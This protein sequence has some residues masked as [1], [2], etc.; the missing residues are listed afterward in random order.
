M[1]LMAHQQTAVEEARRRRFLALFY[2]TGTGKT[3]IGLRVM[4][5]WYRIGLRRFICAVPNTLTGVWLKEADKFEF[6]LRIVRLPVGRA[7]RIALIESNSWDVLVCN[8]EGV[9]NLYEDIVAQRPQGLLCDEMQ[10]L[11]DRSAVQ[12]K[13][14]KAIARAVKQNGGNLI[15]LTGTPVIHS[16]FD[17]WSEFDILWPGA[18][19]TE[20]VL[21]F[22][23]YW[24]FE[25]SVSISRPHPHLR[26]V[27][28][29]EFPPDRLETLRHRVAKHAIEA[30]K[31]ACLDLPDRAFNVVSIDMEPEQQRVYDALKEDFLA[32]LEQRPPLASATEVL[33]DRGISNTDIRPDFTP[34]F[35][36]TLQ[37][38]STRISVTMATTLL[39]RLQQIAAGFAV[40]DDKSVVEL[41]NAKADFVADMLPLW[42]TDTHKLILFA[43]FKHDILVLKSLCEKAKIGYVTLT[44]DNARAAAEVS[45]QFQTDTDIRVFIGN[46]QVSSLGITLTA[47]DYV[48]FF[49]NTFAFG[50][51]LQAMDRPYRFGQTRKV[52][53]YDIVARGTVDES[54]LENQ[55]VKKDLAAMTVGNLKALL[56]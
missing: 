34:E 16:P 50:D 40:A 33:A 55:Q 21:G 32:L 28:L 48:A 42:T 56:R 53:Y 4:E 31:A 52:T 12:S 36:E 29:H 10:R 8:Y 51:R 14:C 24:A 27:R 2:E 9:R 43:R 26:N 15:G 17:L 38:E 3:L 54:I 19:P 6:P 46:P 37:D 44:G 23:N 1:Q 47:A 45:E 11:K 49:T 41:P 13:A 20:H 22:G 35:L 5:D 7:K 18:K 30:T 25:N 39:I